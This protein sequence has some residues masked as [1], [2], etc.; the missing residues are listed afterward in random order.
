MISLN[1]GKGM[2]KMNEQEKFLERI[3]AGESPHDIAEVSDEIFGNW[4]KDDPVFFAQ[5]QEIRNSIRSN[6][7]RTIYQTALAGDSNAASWM[8]SYL[9]PKKNT[10]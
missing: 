2:K 9:Y 1:G 6:L 5:Y 3:K 7:V 4:C 8:L 10:D